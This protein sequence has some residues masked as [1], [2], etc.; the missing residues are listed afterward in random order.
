MVGQM[1]LWMARLDVTGQ[2]FRSLTGKQK[3]LRELAFAAKLERAEILVPRSVG[4]HRSRFDPNAQLVEVFQADI[5]VV[6]GLDEMVANGGGKPGPSFDL[7]HA[8]PTS[9]A[10]DEAA[11][12]VAQLPDLLRITGGAELLSEL[13]ECLL[14][15]LCSFDALLDELDQYAIVAESALAGDGL[16]LPGDLWG[17]GYAAADLC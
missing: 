1:G 17:Q 6:H 14:L 7:R 4:H 10:E 11:Q 16:D 8:S 9:F 2:P 3:C 15:L 12:F 5:A 13:E